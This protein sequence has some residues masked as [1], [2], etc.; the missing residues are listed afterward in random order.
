M[1][2]DNDIG[3][4][5]MTNRRIRPIHSCRPAMG[6]ACSTYL[7]R[8]I[9]VYLDYNSIDIG[10]II[11]VFGWNTVDVVRVRRG[12]LSVTA[13]AA[14]YCSPWSLGGAAGSCS[15]AC[16]TLEFLPGIPGVSMQVIVD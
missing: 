13:V 9:L 15:C 1:R 14:Y 10:Y 5:Y 6:C 11:G 2:K 8:L 4:M 12:W 3:P 16:C 7:D